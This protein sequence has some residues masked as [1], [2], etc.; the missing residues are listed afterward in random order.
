MYW[1]KKNKEETT[2]FKE[3]QSSPIKKKANWFK[4]AYTKKYWNFFCS[5]APT[6]PIK[7]EKK[8]IKDKKN[9]KK[10]TKFKKR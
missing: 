3:K 1:I 6:L 5:K 2:P 4:E 10:Y 7:K 9:F 8:I